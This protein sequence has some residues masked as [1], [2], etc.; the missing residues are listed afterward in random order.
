MMK[1]LYLVSLG[2]TKNLVD[3]E[4]M[5]GRLKDYTLSDTVEDADVIIVNSCG[6]IDSAKEESL[7]TVFELHSQRKEGSLLVMAGCLSERYKEEL[8]KELIEVDLFTGVGDY[9]KIDQ[10]IKEKRSSFTPQVYLIQ[11][12]ERVITNSTYS[13]YIKLSEGCNQQCSF[14]SIPL[15]KGKLQSRPLELVVDEVK[16]LIDKGFKDFTF[17]SQDSSSYLRDQGE[18]EGLIKL[19]EAL[20]KLDLFT[21]RILYLYPSTTSLDLIDAIASSSKVVNYFDMPLQ[22]IS[23]SMLKVMRRGVDQDKI[24]TLLERMRTVP[25]SFLRTAFIVGHPQE[26][27][28]DFLELKKFLER[29]E[30]DRVTLFEYS[31]EEG[32]KAYLLPQ[33]PQEIKQER[34]E[35]LEEIAKRK[36]LESLEKEKEIEVYLDGKSKESD[37]LFSARKTL[38]APEIDGEVLINQTLTNDLEVGGVYKVRVSEIVGEDKLLGTLTSR[39]A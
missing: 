25:G 12:E 2:C 10:L 3:S 21:A 39:I 14:C 37:L 36:V 19:I 31:A 1:K 35:I 18:K 8:Q 32:T 16:R 22:H 34:L 4:V 28:K 17:I 20:E 5:L 27:Q 13:A 11:N 9:A 23:N 33:I 26:E 30:F 29:F 24:L 7:R 15:F 6:F 38:W